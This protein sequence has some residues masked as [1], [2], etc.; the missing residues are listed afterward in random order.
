MEAHQQ[1]EE[2]PNLDQIPTLITVLVVK[3]LAIQANKATNEEAKEGLKEEL[4]EAAKE[5]SEARRK[6][7]TPMMNP[8]AMP[9]MK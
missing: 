3:Y 2:E 1:F 6:P 8:M 9:K 7:K 4:K 5:E